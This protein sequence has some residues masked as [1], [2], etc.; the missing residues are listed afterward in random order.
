MGKQEKKQRRSFTP[1]YRREAAHLVIDTGRPVTR[2]AREVD[3]N[4]GLLGKWVKAERARLAGE[5]DP[6]GAEASSE[7]REELAQLRREVRELRK[8]NEFLGKAAAFF[9][10]KQRPTSGLS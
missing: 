8:D 4:E 3:L 5:V 2:V 1:E 6:G 7:E 10:A 9:A